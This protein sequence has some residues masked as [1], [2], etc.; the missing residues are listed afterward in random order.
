MAEDLRIC[1]PS[2]HEN[3]T[4]ALFSRQ[5]GGSRRGSWTRVPSFCAPQAFAAYKYPVIRLKKKLDREQ[6][7]EHLNCFCYSNSSCTLT[8]SQLD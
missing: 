6:R 7:A 2:S 4:F 8:S 3:T 1:P 5:D